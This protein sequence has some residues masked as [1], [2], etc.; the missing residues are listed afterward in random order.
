VGLVARWLAVSSGA[1]RVWL[2]TDP[3][4]RASQRVAEKAGFVRERLARDHCVRGGMP[5]DCVI[6]ALPPRG[7]RATV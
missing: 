2:E 7:A 3:V 6:Y 5:Q 4:N 1:P